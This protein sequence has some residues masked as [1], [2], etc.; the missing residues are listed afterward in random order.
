MMNKIYSAVWG[1]G[2]GGQ[3]YPFGDATPVSRAD[4]LKADGYLIIWGGEDIHPSIY[5]QE[6][7]GSYVRGDVPSERDRKEMNLISAAMDLGMLTVGICR[8]A[9]LCCAMAGGK[10][11]QDVSGHGNS[12][13][14]VTNNGRTFVTSSV[15]HQ[16]MYPFAVEHEMVAWSHQRRSLRYQGLTALEIEVM[17]GIEP[18]IVY[19]PKQ[20]FLAIQGHPEFMPENCSFNDLCRELI[21]HYG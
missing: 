10:L 14:I 6:P 20:R 4:D 2:G 11:A 1:T 3:G 16:M 18:E 15:H 21:A 9:Q 5:D 19:F 12:H 17:K 8:G 7:N 13:P